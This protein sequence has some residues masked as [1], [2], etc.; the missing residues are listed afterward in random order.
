[1]A[2]RGS[3]GAPLLVRAERGYAV[4]GIHAASIFEGDQ[5]GHIARFVGGQAIGSWVFAK[6]ALALSRQLNTE[7]TRMVS[8]GEF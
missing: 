1:M 6:A 4:V 3:S 8:S 5:R 7:P 2:G